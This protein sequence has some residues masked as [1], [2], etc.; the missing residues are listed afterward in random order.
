MFP[1]SFFVDPKNKYAD[2]FK[3]RF[4]TNFEQRSFTGA[5]IDNAFMIHTSGAS[6][7]IIAQNI[8]QSMSP[9]KPGASI[10]SMA[11]VLATGLDIWPTLH[12]SLIS[13][14]EG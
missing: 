11:L 4:L 8:M 5:F 14:R 6:G 12:R 7:Y 10:I 1:S 3:G 2:V 13:I 9:T